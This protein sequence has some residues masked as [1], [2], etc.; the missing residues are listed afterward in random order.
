VFTVF[1]GR[2]KG[3]KYYLMHNRASVKAHL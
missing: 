2:A 3:L 1:T